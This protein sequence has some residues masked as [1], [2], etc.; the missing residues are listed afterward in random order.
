MSWLKRR[1]GKEETATRPPAIGPVV[2]IAGDEPWLPRLS[3][4]GRPVDVGDLQLDSPALEQMR[5]QGVELLVPM[6]SHG[7][8]ISVMQLGHRLS[9]QPYSADDRALLSGVASGAAP[10]LRV[11]QLLGE[12][13]REARERERVENELRVAQLIQ[14]HFLPSR[15]PEREGWTVEA[16]YQPAREVGGDFYDF[17]DFDDGRLG[18]VAGDVTD[19]G[20]PAALVMTSKRTLIRA[21]AQRLVEPAEV[22]KRVNAQ[23]CADIPA[24]M[25]V[26]CLYGIL[27]TERGEFRFANAGHNLPI[28]ISG[29]DATEPLCTGMPLGLVADAE[30]DEVT[31]AVAPYDSVVIYSDALPEA[32]DR[33]GLMYG[34]DAVRDSAAKA[35]DGPVVKR[36]LADLMAFTGPD[37]EQEDDVTIVALRRCAELVTEKLEI[38]SVP[39]NE[40][41]AIDRVDDFARSLLSPE[42]LESL[43]T[44]VG[45]ATMNAIEHGNRADASI[46]VELSFARTPDSLIVRIADRG[47]G[48][49]PAPGLPDLEAKLAGEEPARGWGLFLIE[50]MVDRVRSEVTEDRHIVELTVVTREV[51]D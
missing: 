6:I 37:W 43:K 33:Q 34:F 26:T 14:Q 31:V 7:E 8:L 19:K 30:Y 13:E 32:H 9:D 17:I 18:V 51:N 38:P 25:F 12:R 28:H 50:E 2:D 41:Q 5:R 22:L 20:V 3:S 44:A 21:S 48:G 16:H 40:R 49:A 39:G 42:R 23:L 4:V 10:A 15:L 46:P 35:G 11:A 45:E 29:D 1:R 27:D 36:L 24:N 47:N